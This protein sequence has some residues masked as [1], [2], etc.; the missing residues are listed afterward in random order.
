MDF[1]ERRKLLI[2]VNPFGGTK[3]GHFIWKT[4][5]PILRLAGIE[6]SIRCEYSLDN[7][8]FDD[9]QDLINFIRY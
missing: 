4:A 2:L 9:K 7:F 8:N 1:I 3:Q 5:E 6:L